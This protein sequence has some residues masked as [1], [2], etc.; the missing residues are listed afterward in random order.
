MPDST[1][2]ALTGAEAIV[3]NMATDFDN[4]VLHLWQYG[5]LA[6]S[7]TTPLAD[8]TAAECDFSGY[9]AETITDWGAPFLLDAS[10]ALESQNRFDY[11]S[12]AGSTGNQVGGWYLVSAGGD[13]IA[14]GVY[15]PSRPAQGDGQV[16]FTTVVLPIASGQVL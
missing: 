10:W 1:S 5:E 16:I 2:Y 8:F 6:P 13:L 14:F 7:P 3:T 11:D 12:G 15:D 9:A 4:A